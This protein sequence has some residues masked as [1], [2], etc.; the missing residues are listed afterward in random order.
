MIIPFILKAP[1]ENSPSQSEQC[2]HLIKNTDNALIQRNDTPLLELYSLPKTVVKHLQSG[3]F[4]SMLIQSGFSY[5]EG[6]YFKDAQGQRVRVP[7]LPSA[8]GLPQAS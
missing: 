2:L 3:Q 7:K 4:S 6:S 8:I 1:S 5:T